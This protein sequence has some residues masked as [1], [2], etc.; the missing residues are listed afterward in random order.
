MKNILHTVNYLA[1]ALYA[2]FFTLNGAKFLASFACRELLSEGGGNLWAFL[3][4][5]KYF[6]LNN[7]NYNSHQRFS[8]TS[9]LNSLRQLKFISRLPPEKLLW[10]IGGRKLNFNEWHNVN[11][12]DDTYHH[13]TFC[14]RKSFV[15]RWLVDSLR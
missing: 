14:P 7:L 9:P 5:F 4:Y 13:K 8:F 2:N 11:H 1:L 6:P 12:P 15:A 10:L 3:N